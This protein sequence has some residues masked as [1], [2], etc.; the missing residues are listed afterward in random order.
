M[1]VFKKEVRKPRHNT[2]HQAWV[3]LDGGFAK[4]NCTILNLSTTGARI[5]LSDS[6]SIGNNLSLALTGDVRKVTR[7][8]LVWRKDSVVGVEFIER[9]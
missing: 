1:A 6:G 3:L 2:Q 4:R 8:R 7:C 9:T 5:K